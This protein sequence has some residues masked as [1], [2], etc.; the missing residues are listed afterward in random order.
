MLFLSKEC[1]VHGNTIHH[2][3]MLDKKLSKLFKY[4]QLGGKR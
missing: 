2:V 3:V 1:A 4:K